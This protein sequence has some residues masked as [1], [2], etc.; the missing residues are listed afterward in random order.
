VERSRACWV[1]GAP[2]STFS[3]QPPANVNDSAI[4][5]LHFANHRCPGPLW[6]W[7]TVRGRHVTAVGGGG[8][9]DICK[10]RRAIT[11]LSRSTT[12]RYQGPADLRSKARLS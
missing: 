5:R 6:K 11:L 4:R 8:R 3:S 10:S 7:G 12:P 1:D 9:L 2:S